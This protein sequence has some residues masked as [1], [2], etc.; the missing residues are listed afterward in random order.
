[1]APNS[2]EFTLVAESGIHPQT[3]E[4][5]K[6]VKP[7]KVPSMRDDSLYSDW[8]KEIEIWIITN[9]TLG[10]AKSVLSGTLF[11]SLTGQARNTVLSTLKVKDITSEDGVKNILATLDEFFLDN[12]VKNAFEVH[13]EL[14]KYKRKPT[15]SYKEFLV[16]FNLKVN[17]VRLSGTEL[18]D[19]VLGYMM[20]NCANLSAEK[21]N[22][23]RATCTKLDLKSVKSQLDKIA[24]D[25]SSETKS[26]YTAAKSNAPTSSIKVEDAFYQDPRNWNNNDSSDDGMSD[27][28]DSYYGYNTNG[29]RF[30]I[31]H[32]DKFQLNPLDKHGHVSKCDHCHCIYHWLLDCPYAP[33]HLKKRN[34]NRRNDG[35]RSFNNSGFRKPL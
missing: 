29:R 6:A 22:M 21:E 33:D 9:E 15:T 19:G 4:M 10:C 1:M 7:T 34:N 35:N 16:E 28:C 11:E 17:K 5:S 26:S 13:D 25:S 24:L 31:H 30:K 23:I 32:K 27:Q 12:E 8:K 3:S 2:V 14:T 20:L 18:S